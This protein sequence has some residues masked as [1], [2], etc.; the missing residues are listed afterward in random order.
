M[1]LDMYLGKINKKVSDDKELELLCSIDGN[2]ENI[3]QEKELIDK[4]DI[5]TLVKK[6]FVKSFYEDYI[7]FKDMGKTGLSKPYKQKFSFNQNLTNKD[8]LDFI[9]KAIKDHCNDINNKYNYYM[10]NKELI[11]NIVVSNLG[12]FRKHSDLHGYF[13]DIYFDRGGDKEFNCVKLS[14]TEEDIKKVIEIAENELNGVSAVNKAQGFFWGDTTKEDWEETFN[15]F[16]NIL[17]TTDF[18]NETVYYDSW[19]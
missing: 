12:Y 16:T 10:S 4:N 18:D 11:D 3:M 17:K 19:W 15:V 6:V 7:K 2:Q 5:D 9:L 8:R 1:G 13:E 14:L